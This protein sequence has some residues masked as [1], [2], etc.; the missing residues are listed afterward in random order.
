MEYNILKTQKTQLFGNKVP[1]IRGYAMPIPNEKF[2][3][4]R[5]GSIWIKKM[6]GRKPPCSYF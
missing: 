4:E 2:V 5:L 6:R 3:L 1:K